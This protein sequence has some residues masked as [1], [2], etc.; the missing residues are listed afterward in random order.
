MP[1]A[2][3]SPKRRT[4]L[5]IAAREA[6]RRLR[7]RED[8]DGMLALILGPA[9]LEPATAEA[10]GRRLQ[11]LGQPGLA[12]VL[13][14]AIAEALRQLR[15]ELEGDGDLAPVLGAVGVVDRL[16]DREQT[17]AALAR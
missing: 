2:P 13:R 6:R 8:L 10:A 1:P 5:P 4:G 12:S 3:A 7:L 17:H 16:L 15:E 14:Q 9:P 11:R